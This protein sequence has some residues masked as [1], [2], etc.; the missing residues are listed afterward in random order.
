[1]SELDQRR[2]RRRSGQQLFDTLAI[3]FLT[4]P[5][6][7]RD[8]TFGSNGLR[9]DTKFFAFIGRDGQLVVKLP[10][11]Q[12]AALVSAD[13]ASPIRIGRNTTREWIGAPCPADHSS[14]EQWRG[15]LTDA[16]DY[17]ASL[18]SFVDRL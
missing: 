5:H 18:T 3:Y 16:Y 15:L 6:V 8:N 7:N 17:A 1:M 14:P 2:I 13:E 11:A 4:Q 10:V 9:I 12:A